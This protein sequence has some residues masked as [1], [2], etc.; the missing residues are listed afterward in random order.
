M[1]TERISEA[2]LAQFKDGDDALMF[3]YPER[4]SKVINTFLED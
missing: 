1:L 2:W 3:Q 4:L